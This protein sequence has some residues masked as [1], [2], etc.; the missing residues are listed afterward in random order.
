MRGF[1]I[2]KVYLLSHALIEPVLRARQFFGPVGKML[3]SAPAAV[4][5]HFIL[6]DIQ[7]RR[8]LAEPGSIGGEM[9]VSSPRFRGVPRLLIRA[10]VAIKRVRHPVPPRG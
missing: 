1:V 10:V 5:P 7:S 6:L 4:F 2:F 3:M 8:R 9:H